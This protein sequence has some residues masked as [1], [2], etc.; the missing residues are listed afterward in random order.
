MR[1]Q[2]RMNSNAKK[3]KVIE[4]FTVVVCIEKINT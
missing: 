4:M 1:I 3:Y 2:L